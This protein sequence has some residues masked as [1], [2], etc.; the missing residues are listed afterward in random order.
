MNERKCPI[1]VHEYHK[2]PSD[3]TYNDYSTKSFAKTASSKSQNSN[4]QSSKSVLDKLEET[5]WATW[6]PSRDKRVRTA[7]RPKKTSKNDA[8]GDTSDTMVKYF[9][10]SNYKESS[11]SV[12]DSA[13]KYD[14]RASQS[15]RLIELN[16][17]EIQTDDF[18][19]WVQTEQE[20]KIEENDEHENPVS[21]NTDLE[22]E[23]TEQT[24]DTDIIPV[25]ENLTEDDETIPEIS[26]K[27]KF[28]EHKDSFIIH[29]KKQEEV[30]ES[31]QQ[32]KCIKLFK[33]PGSGYIR[34]GTYPLK[35]C[36][37]NDSTPKGNFR[38]GPPGSP[39]F[40]TTNSFNRK[41]GK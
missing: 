7:R 24:D 39:M 31:F 22:K 26:S 30:K 29:K 2:I 18:S 17:Q 8:Y 21:S 11:A 40:V 5:Y 12:D 3:S 32:P 23:H 41:Y 33:K 28:L 27:S 14:S 34:G 35:S 15:S 6:K 4:S 10:K 1:Y 9:E 19:T 16:T 13:Y 38:L 20:N 37:K 25:K 36:F